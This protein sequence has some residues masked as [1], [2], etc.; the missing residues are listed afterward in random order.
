MTHFD[1]AGIALLQCELKILVQGF[2]SMTQACGVLEL[3]DS[4]D[5]FLMSLCGHTLTDTSSLDHSHASKGEGVTSP[6]GIYFMTLITLDT[7]IMSQGGR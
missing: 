3:S 1:S 2:Q 4:R 5:A 7:L 6:T